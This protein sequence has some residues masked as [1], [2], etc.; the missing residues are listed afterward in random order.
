MGVSAIWGDQ[1]LRENPA[2]DQAE[3]EARGGHLVVIYQGLE[4]GKY[5]AVCHWSSKP[6]PGPDD[7]L[8]PSESGLCWVGPT[9]STAAEAVFDGRTHYRYF[10]P[11]I[12]FSAIAERGAV[13][14]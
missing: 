2:V 1:D 8:T 9:R 10:E 12:H 4:E 14:L 7:S 3:I 13:G 5:G 11:W 6:L